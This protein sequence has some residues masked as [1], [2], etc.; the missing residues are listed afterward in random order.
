MAEVLSNTRGDRRHIIQAELVDE[1]VHLQQQAERL[2][3]ATGG[4]QECDLQIVYAAPR[5]SNGLASSELHTQSVHAMVIA[6]HSL[7]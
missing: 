7:R 2:P 6:S 1:L 3:D 5:P 4:T